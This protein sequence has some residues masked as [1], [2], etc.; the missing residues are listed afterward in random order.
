MDHRTYFNLGISFDNI[1]DPS[2]ANDNYFKVLKIIPTH[3]NSMFNIGMNLVLLS[4]KE[5]AII[6]FKKVIYLYP[7]D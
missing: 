1:G 3:H 2:A 7:L 4:K 5:E 6:I